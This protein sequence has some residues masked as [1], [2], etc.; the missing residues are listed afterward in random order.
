MLTVIRSS[1]VATF[2]VFVP[3]QI[4]FSQTGVAFDV[5]AIAKA[6][7]IAIDSITNEKTVQINLPISITSDVKYRDNIDEYRLDIGWNQNTFLLEDF[8]PKTKT[9]STIQGLVNVQRD[10]TQSATL[11]FNASGTPL[12]LSSARI[13]SDL[14]WG[15]SRHETFQELPQHQT[16]VASGTI[17]RGT[18]AFFRFHPSPTI[19]LEG[20][21]E[22]TLTYRVPSNWETGI[23]KV[24]CRAIGTN[25]IAGLWKEPFDFGRS[26]VVPVYEDQNVSAQKLVIDFV[27]AEQ[28]LRRS[29]MEVEE[30]MKKAH[31]FWRVIQSQP[32]ISDQWHHRLIQSGDDQQFSE[33]R[34]YLTE[35]VASAADA[36]VKARQNLS[37][38]SR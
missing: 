18:G 16:L 4:L 17:D 32:K 12:E 38:V 27:S 33:F 19:T 8:E 21:R 10:R 13:A 37:S 26:F 6:N 9:G 30:Q 24:E 35:E 1:F 14:G 34:G 5:P 2:C 22:L 20:S 11:S 31:P 23:L 29:W 28:E 36:F 7:V 3:A 25:Q 15:N